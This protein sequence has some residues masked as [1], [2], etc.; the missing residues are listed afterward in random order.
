MRRNRPDGSA[1]GSSTALNVRVNHENHEAHPSLVKREETGS[2]SWRDSPASHG[3]EVAKMGTG[4]QAAWQSPP[5][6]GQEPGPGQKQG[7]TL[8]PS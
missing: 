8:G 5:P 1:A 2:G 3:K 7:R 4:P 6:C